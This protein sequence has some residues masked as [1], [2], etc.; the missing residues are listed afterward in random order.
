MPN[1]KTLELNITHEILE[2]CRRY[3]PRAFAFGT[4]LIQERHQGYD[5]KILARFSPS[6]LTSPLQYKKPVNSKNLGRNTFEYIFDIN[7]NTYHDQHLILYHHL[8]GGKRRVAFYALPAVFTDTEFYSSLPSYVPEPFWLTWLR[9][10]LSGLTTK[11]IG[12]IC[13][14]TFGWHHFNPKMK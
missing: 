12:Y 1:E 13:S 2:I 4:T 11:D 14:R 5:S 9:F 10:N 7:N 3:D 8:A 6:W